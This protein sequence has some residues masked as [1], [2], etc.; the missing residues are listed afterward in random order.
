MQPDSQTACHRTTVQPPYLVVV[1][2][3]SQSTEFKLVEGVTIFAGSGK[4]CGILLG[5]EDVSHFHCMFCLNQGRLWVQ[6]CETDGQTIVNGHPIKAEA[7]LSHG[8]RLTIG[9]NQI[10]VVLI[11]DAAVTTS[12]DFNDDDVI[13]S[14][15]CEQFVEQPGRR[16]E[17]ECDSMVTRQSTRNQ[18]KVSTDAYDYEI[19]RMNVDESSEANE[20]AMPSDSDEVS[21][22]RAE[23]E[24]LQSELSERDAELATLRTQQFSNSDSDCSEDNEDVVRLVNRLD[25]LVEELQFSDQRHND[26]AEFLRLSDEANQ[27]EQEER[28]QLESWIQ[29]IEQRVSQRTAESEAETARILGRNQD[30][31]EQLN[32]AET[33]IRKMTQPASSSSSASEAH[34][35]MIQELRGRHDE[36]TERLRVANEENERFRQEFQVKNANHGDELRKLEQKIVELELDACRERAEICRQRAD[37]ERSKSELEKKL[38]ESGPLS[39]SDCRFAAMRQHLRDLHEQE[40]LTLEEKR[41]RSLSGRI[42]NLL[43]RVGSR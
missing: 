7:V 21:F 32:R 28:R 17:S 19:A 15:V 27:A 4:T 43:N 6:D 38:Q 26:L 33:Y 36:M 40:K 11:L 34:S 37:L 20:L 35:E 9:N 8:D 13:E 10:D 31:Q 42:A 12:V 23:V 18:S 3:K 1:N 2:E 30:I 39:D 5:G 29:G 41:R 24:H 25:E 16:E 22:L 14:E